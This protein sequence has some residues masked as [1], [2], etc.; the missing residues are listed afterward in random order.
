[1]TISRQGLRNVCTYLEILLL[2]FEEEVVVTGEEEVEEDVVDAVEDFEL[3]AGLAIVVNRLQ[4]HR[5]LLDFLVL[6]VDVED[7]ELR[8]YQQ[9]R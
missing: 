2:L 8:A 6:D 4:D 1:M 3:R 5:Y 9:L 7:L